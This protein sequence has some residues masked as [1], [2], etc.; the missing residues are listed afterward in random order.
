[1]DANVQIRTATA[2]D[3]VSIMRL[4]DGALLDAD[5]ATVEERIARDAVLVAVAG[6]GTSERVVGA[7]VLDTPERR[8][9]APRP[10]ERAPDTRHVEAVAVHRRHRRS[11]VGT[12]LVET[13][14]D[15]CD[16]L[17]AAFR[18]EIRPFYE[19]LGFDVEADA[20]TD[21]DADADAD[22]GEPER[23]HGMR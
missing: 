18:G 14:A 22:N 21:T 19:S 11:G 17:T 23:Y 13:A 6:D 2:D 12:A 5:A 10:E 15:R 4:L 20:K 7:L 3:L 9:H 1:M 16:Y 8:A